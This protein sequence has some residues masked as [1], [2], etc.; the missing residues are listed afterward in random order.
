M[1]RF[2][3]RHHIAI[4]G[5]SILP[6]RVIRA[7]NRP[8][9]DIYDPELADM[10]Y[11]VIKDLKTVAGTNG[12]ATI[13]ICNGH[14]VWEGSLTNF[15]SKGDKVL[16]LATGIFAQ[17][18][19]G[20]AH[21]LGIEVETLDFGKTSS[22][23]SAR[24]VER[25]SKD[26]EH[27]IKAILV[28]QVDTSTSV[29]NDIKE[30]A[31]VVK[32]IN[33]PALIA[34]DCIASLGCEVFCMDDWQ[35]DIMVSGSQKGLMIPPGL[36]FI[37]FN[38]RA[39]EAGKNADL[40][41][42]YWDW[43]R[44]VD[45]EEFYQLFCGTAPTHHLFALREALNMILYEEGLPQVLKRHVVMAEAIWAAFDAWGSKGQVEMNIRDKNY[46][47]HSVS[48]IKVVPPNGKLLRKWTP[49]H[50]GLTLGIGLGMENEQDPNSTGYFR[51][52]HMGHLNPNMILGLLGSIETGFEHLEISRGKG[53]IEAAA[54]VIAKAYQPNE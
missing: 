17:G 30:I 22:V 23:D 50:A 6:D 1:S 32:S 49:E 19:G 48:T 11:G 2:F 47:S 8:S 41:T 21:A 10:V 28:V 7:M 9:P 43:E 33:H 42:P 51:I 34:V 31:R 4:P 13:Y 37:Y 40:R 38:E 26:K 39:R 44:R 29:R 53:A 12:Y 36:G 54:K 5:P 46:R 27:K 35:V 20:F 15:L 52:G 3:G 45:P 25:L 18:W 16:V 24:V 14:G